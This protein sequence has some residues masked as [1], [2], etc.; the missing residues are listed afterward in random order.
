EVGTKINFGATGR[1]F[2]NLAAF[3]YDYRDLQVSV[4]ID[5]AL[6]AQV[7]NAGSAEVWGV[8]ADTQIA[9]GANGTFRASV[10]YVKPTYE[11]LLAS[12]PVVCVNPGCAGNGSS[13][14]GDLQTRPGVITQPDLGGR[15][16]PQTPNWTI[17]VGYD[18]E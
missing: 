5:S 2:V 16:P 4:L 3:Y 11:T 13:A 9:V 7:F 17:S 12:I 15:K 14:V 8:E 1:N 18:H 10:N 6:G